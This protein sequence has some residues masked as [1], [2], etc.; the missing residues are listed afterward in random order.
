MHPSLAPQI[1][2]HRT[3]LRTQPPQIYLLLGMVFMYFF[4]R[5]AYI[6]TS[7]MRGYDMARKKGDKK[8]AA[9]SAATASGSVAGSS[10]AAAGTRKKK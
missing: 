7:F 2:R 4:V 8:G 6:K 3:A 1:G 9:G 5:L 10:K